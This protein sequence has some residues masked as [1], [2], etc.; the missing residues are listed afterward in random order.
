M[1]T[2]T[3]TKE[4]DAT[5]TYFRRTVHDSDGSLLSDERVKRDPVLVFMQPAPAAID[6]VSGIAVVSLVFQFRDF[7]GEARTDSGAVEFRLRERD[8]PADDGVTF[9]R[10]LVAG[11]LAL[12][13][14]VDSPG[15]YFLT[16]EPPLLADMQ[17]AELV[18][19]KVE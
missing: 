8:V 9:T 6:E 12:T 18:R 17:L 16:V 2:E 4:T 5:G 7:D 14:E 10:Q 1:N 15:E 19:V 13:L 11:E 3:I